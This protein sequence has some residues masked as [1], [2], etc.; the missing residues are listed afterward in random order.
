META[1]RYLPASER[2]GW[3]LVP[4]LSERMEDY[5]KAPAEPNDLTLL[6]L[7]DSFTEFQDQSG[8]NYIRYAEAQIN[9][10]T[11]KINAFNLSEAGTDVDRYQSIFCAATTQRKPDI[12]VFGIYIGNDVKGFQ[13][14]IKNIDCTIPTTNSELN[15]RAWLKKSLILNATF[16]LAKIYLPWARS[17]F[18]EN[19]KA[20]LTKNMSPTEVAMAEA[21]IPKEM[22]KLAKSD[23]INPWDVAIALVDPSLYRSL[24]E[25]KGTPIAEN[26]NALA[27]E[28][29]ILN[30][31]CEQTDIKC[32]F[33]V[34]PVAPWVSHRA[35]Q[36]FIQLTY[37]V[38]GLEIAYP[39]G[40]QNF[41]SKL[42]S[43]GVPTLDL[44]PALRRAAISESLFI[45]KDIHFN[46]KGQQVAGNALAKKMHELGWL[47]D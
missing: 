6:A 36:Y 30:Q 25:P 12:A 46:Q 21:R 37:D 9:L 11:R 3:Q 22:V 33:V 44:L 45:A 10:E 23:A 40:L 8:G 27:D 7:G 19:T 43:S 13:R 5:F 31:Q 24:A 38:F 16:R 28:I 41:L 15:L 1:Y 29:I 18:Y 20:Y 47:R 34:I 2:L 17:N 35:Q 32:L 14:P 4:S 42:S 39:V 26:Y